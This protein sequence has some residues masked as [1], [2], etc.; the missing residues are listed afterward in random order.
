MRFPCLAL[1]RV[2]LD[3]MLEFSGVTSHGTPHICF[4]VDID[5]PVTKHKAG[6]GENRVVGAALATQRAHFAVL[7]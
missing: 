5:A 2:N 7:G 6:G 3:E 4:D 1:R